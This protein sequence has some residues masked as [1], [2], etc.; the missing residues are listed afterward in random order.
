MFHWIDLLHLE[1]RP[2]T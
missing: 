1:Y 2:I